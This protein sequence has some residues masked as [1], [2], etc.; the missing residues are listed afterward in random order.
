MLLTLKWLFTLYF[1]LKNLMAF[2]EGA[3]MSRNG[4]LQFDN[5]GDDTKIRYQSVRAR[6][7]QSVRFFPQP[8]FSLDLS[9]LNCFSLLSYLRHESLFG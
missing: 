8:K 2:S 9:R 7:L 5:D 6:F 3:P 4:L 1:L